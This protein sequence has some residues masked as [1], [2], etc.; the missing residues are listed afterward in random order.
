MGLFNGVVFINH[1][2][3]YILTLGYFG[4]GF[5]MKS[6]GRH[7]MTVLMAREWPLR[8]HGV[9]TPADPVNNRVSTN[10]KMC[11]AGYKWLVR[12]GGEEFV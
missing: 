1:S 6:E 2:L 7:G 11:Q 12:Q 5:L 10:S 9:S 4:C 3:N 8:R